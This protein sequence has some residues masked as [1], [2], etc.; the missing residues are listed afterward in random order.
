[1]IK[2]QFKKDEFAE[3]AQKE[4]EK[5]GY[6]GATEVRRNCIYTLKDLTSREIEE[7][8]DII[9]KHGGEANYV[10]GVL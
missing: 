3:N 5:S 4:I 2:Y 10:I 7:I 6:E 9:K 8:Q 1:M